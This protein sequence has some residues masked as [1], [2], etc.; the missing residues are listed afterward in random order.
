MGPRRPGGRLGVA[1]TLAISSIS[2]YLDIKICRM[3]EPHGGAT[4]GVVAEDHPGEVLDVEV[5]DDAGTGRDHPEIV[6]GGLAATQALGRL[7]VA[8]VLDSRPCARRPRAYSTF[9]VDPTDIFRMISSSLRSITVTVLEA[10]R[11]SEVTSHEEAR[12]LPQGRVRRAM[13]LRG[14]IPRHVVPESVAR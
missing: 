10:S 9:A 1:R 11:R 5:V 14:Q 8:L 3:G 2:F 4:Q 13:E 7:L 6:E 12:G